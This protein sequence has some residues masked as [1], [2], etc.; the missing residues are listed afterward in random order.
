MSQGTNA[1]Y[2]LS[3][4]NVL[5]CHVDMSWV[6]IICDPVSSSSHVN[7]M[8]HQS[9]ARAILSLR[10]SQRLGLC[11]LCDLTCGL[12][13]MRPVAQCAAYFNPATQVL[14]HEQFVQ[15]DSVLSIDN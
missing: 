2:G 7:S 3:L 12:G 4:C 10:S 8:I 1:S 11:Y 13:H 9:A 15:L 14:A 6:K 5:D